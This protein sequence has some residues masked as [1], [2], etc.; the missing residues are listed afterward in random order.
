MANNGCDVMLQNINEYVGENARL[1]A[2]AEQNLGLFQSCLQSSL[3]INVESGTALQ[4]TITFPKISHTFPA[5]C[6]LLLIAALFQRVIKSMKWPFWEDENL[7]EIICSRAGKFR[8]NAVIYSSV[9]I[10]ICN[11]SNINLLLYSALDC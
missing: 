4:T 9:F 10:L 2:P 3:C 6:Q 1:M 7:S 5:H 11:D 8:I